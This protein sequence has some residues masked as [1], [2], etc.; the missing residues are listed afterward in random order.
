VISQ[1]MLKSSGLAEEARGLLN[2]ISIYTRDRRVL[3]SC[4]LFGGRCVTRAAVRWSL[5]SLRLCDPAA[6]D[7]HSQTLD[8]GSSHLEGV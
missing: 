5:P 3:L 1:C 4:E 6:L 7:I 2:D 8:S